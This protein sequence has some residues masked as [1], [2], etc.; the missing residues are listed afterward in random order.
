MT[1]A[2]P[3]DYN[4]AARGQKKPVDLEVWPNSLKYAYWVFVVAAVYLALTGLAG[5]FGPGDSSK[6]AFSQFRAENRHFVSW[7]NLAAAIII[8]LVA[9][10]L[11]RAMKHARTILAAVVGLSCFF[12]I[13][14]IAIGAGGLLL[15]AIPFLLLGATVLMYRPDANEFIRENNRPTLD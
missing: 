4:R 15:V 3:H 13:A 7:T 12:N 11:A 9:P 2:F 8:A 10:Q 1:N 5:F 6:T 14:A